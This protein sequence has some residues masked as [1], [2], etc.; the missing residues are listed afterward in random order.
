MMPRPGRDGY[1]PTVAFFE[2]DII[3]LQELDANERY[4]PLDRM[5]V[6][7]GLHAA[8]VA[9][10]IGRMP[11]LAAGVR[12]FGRDGLALRIDLVPLWLTTIDP[13]SVDPQVRSRLQLHQREAASI[14][15]Q[16]FK[17]QGFSPQDELLPERDE[18]TPADQA[19]QGMMA[20]A[21]LA[22]Q[23]MMVERQLDAARIEGNRVGGAERSEQTNAAYDLAR[24]VRR[25]AHGL[26]A[27]SRR[28]EYGGV[29]SGLYRQFGINSYRNLHYGRLREALDWLERWYGDMQG[30]PEPPPDI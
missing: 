8:D 9:N 14:L 26:A 1:D 10:A 2:D 11:L 22:R 4:V 13:A 19:Y 27:R 16:A 17:P 23:Q 18:M 6:T 25:I 21:T 15:W 7:L 28:N 12:A 24:G 29:F 5:C 3:A 30:E 20:Q